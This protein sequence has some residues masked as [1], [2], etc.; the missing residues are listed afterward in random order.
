[1]SNSKNTKQEFSKKYFSIE[2]AESLLPKIESILTR[3]IK[4]NKALEILESIEIEVYDDD[5]EDLRRITK[6]NRQF[7]KLSYEFY[8]NVE[9]LESMGCLVKDYEIGLVD[10]YCKFEGR[11]IFLCWKLGEKT[12][13]FWHE[14]D[15]GYMER[16]PIV[17]LTK[18]W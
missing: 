17:D 1:M 5:Y 11:E 4:L 6:I 8:A 10:F 13:K 12:V 18:G 7:H 14:V 2:E 16:K 3:T 15:E 9:K